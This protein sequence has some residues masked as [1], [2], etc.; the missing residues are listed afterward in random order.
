MLKPR[1]AKEKQKNR[2]TTRY[3]INSLSLYIY[4]TFCCTVVVTKEAVLE[5]EASEE[6]FDF[7]SLEH[8]GAQICLL[9]F[10]CEI[11]RRWRTRV[12]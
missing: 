4:T 1:T 2:L 5:E 9:D 6:A 7:L 10:A 11:F 3:I 12:V 8:H